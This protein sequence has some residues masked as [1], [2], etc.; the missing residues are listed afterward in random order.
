LLKEYQRE[1]V[2]RLFGA[3][4]MTCTFDPLTAVNA[5]RNIHYFGMKVEDYRQDIRADFGG[6]LNRQDI[7][8]DRFFIAWNLAAPPRRRPGPSSPSAATPSVTRVERARVNGRGGPLE[9]EKVAAVNLRLKAPALL[10]QIPQDFYL[11][12]REAEVEDPEVRRIPLDWRLETRRA[13][14]HYLGKG[15]RVVDFLQTRKDPRTCY[16][17]LR[18]TGD[19]VKESK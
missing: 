7:P 6:L 14:R 9:L 5:F 4:V 10:V 19:R 2:L 3:T 12:L 1:Q 16:Y 13:F 8:R 18:K 17:L 11:M 15:Y